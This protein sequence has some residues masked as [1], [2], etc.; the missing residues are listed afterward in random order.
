MILV[1]QLF[2]IWKITWVIFIFVSFVT[3]HILSHDSSVIPYPFKR[4]QAKNRPCTST[5]VGI[6]R[7]RIEKNNSLK[8]FKLLLKTFNI[9]RKFDQSKILWFTSKVSWSEAGWNIGEINFEIAR[10]IF[11]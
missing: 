2:L 4:E 3:S 5:F 6:P 8:L 1:L 9:G 11:T 7:I 10:S